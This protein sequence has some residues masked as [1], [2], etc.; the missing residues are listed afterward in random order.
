MSDVQTSTVSESGASTTS[1]TTDFDLS[2]DPTGRRGPTPNEVL[3]ADYAA[4]FVPALRGASADAGR[5]D[6]GRIQIDADGETDAEGDLRAI[7][8]VVH[9]AAAVGDEGDEVVADAMERCHLHAALR[10]ELHATVTLNGDA[11]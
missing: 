7:S 10:E 2:I 6:L 3:V 5:G 1:Q 8:F 11:F 4:C 9:V